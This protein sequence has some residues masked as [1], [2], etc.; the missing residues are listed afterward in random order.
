MDRDLG[1]PQPAKRCLHHHLGREFH[2]RRSEIKC[3]NRAPPECPKATVEIVAGTLEEQ[4]ADRREY[5]IADVTVQPWHRI[6]LDASG[7]AI[8]HHEV[9]PL[10]QLA[11]EGADVGEFVAVIGVA[12][13]H[14]ATACGSDPAHERAAISLG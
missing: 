7:K 8:S 10:A 2:A 5:R 14:E 13:N 6:R 11:D 1:D 3:L 9:V 4:P 12:H